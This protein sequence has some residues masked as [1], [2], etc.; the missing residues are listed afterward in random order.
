MS[1]A[2]SEPDPDD[3][4]HTLHDVAVSS[5]TD[6]LALRYRAEQELHETKAQLEE[7]SAALS[8]SVSLL[9]ATL[10]SA[11]DGIVAYDLS[12]RIMAHNS[13]FSAIWGVQSVD[14]QL[15]AF[16]I[17]KRFA[18][19][20]RDPDGFLQAIQRSRLNPEL[21]VFDV[22]DFLDGRTFERVA[23]PQR[24]D[25]TCVGVVAHWRDVTEARRSA[26]AQIALAEQLRQVQKME[27]LGALSGGIAHDFNNILGAILGNAELALTMPSNVASVVESLTA[28]KEAAERAARLVQQILTFSRQQ[29]HERLPI[30]LA[31]TV[32]E[33]ARLLR[34]TIPAGIELNTMLEADEPLIM[35]DA[36]Q[37]HQIVMN[38]CTN[39]MHALRERTAGAGRVGQIDIQVDHGRT[40]VGIGLEAPGVLVPGRFVRMKVS[41]NG[42]GMS[43]QTQARIFDPFFTTRQP[44]D[45]TG[46]GLSVV[47]GIM[48]THGGAITVH[49]EL[50]VGTTFTLYFPANA[51]EPEIAR[52]TP[53][54]VEALTYDVGT[55]DAIRV[56]YVDDDQMIVSLVS[57]LLAKSACVVTGFARAVDALDMI[58]TRPDDF[59]VVVT[60]FNM[61]ELS[62]LDIARA[63]LEIRPDLPV[64]IT[65]GYLT[66]ELQAEAV[67]IGVHQLLFK[68]DLAKRLLQVVR[69][70]PRAVRPA[71]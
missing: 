16:E 52:K 37:L 23:V 61:P 2:V 22:F 54:M 36:T 21:E 26:D 13:R 30:A 7:R 4:A 8:M 57:R 32:K 51:D 35:G 71:L 66:N 6:M 9:N 43:P 55:T 48:E 29:P 38:L 33:A 49:S 42:V 70:V 56:L 27:S 24:I 15:A 1:S 3:G 14:L 25:S 45:G 46:L 20:L 59:D 10:E 69:S 28:I 67:R 40:G 39:A 63:V 5:S 44:G 53:L 19:Q 34:A 17:A 68:P 11:P 18:P 50:D 12:G 62:G 60:D 31:D 58:R 47:H 41:D 65:S 64:V